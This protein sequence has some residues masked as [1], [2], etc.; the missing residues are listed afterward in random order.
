[1]QSLTTAALGHLMLYTPSEYTGSVLS[2]LPNL[3]LL[4]ELSSTASFFNR[5]QEW[6]IGNEHTQFLTKW[7]EQRL[8]WPDGSAFEFCYTMTPPM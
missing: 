5:I 2:L 1:M 8:A 6:P 3:R 7:R 4:H